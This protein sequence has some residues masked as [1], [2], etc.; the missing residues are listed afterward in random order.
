MEKQRKELQRA[1]QELEKSHRESQERIK[2][3]TRKR[4]DR[5]NQS[6]DRE[7]E[8]TKEPGGRRRYRKLCSSTTSRGKRDSRVWTFGLE[9]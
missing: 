2:E 7:R 1:L 6:L 4:N 9:R 8:K 5:S 3:T